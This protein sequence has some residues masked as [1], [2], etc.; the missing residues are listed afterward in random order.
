MGMSMLREK[1]LAKCE[2]CGTL[3]T[4]N[5]STGVCQDCWDKDEE[6]FQKV[7]SAIK[8]GQRVLPDE[9]AT[10]TGVELKHINRWIQQG[11][12]G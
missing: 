4:G 12:F 6:M 9:L 8:F 11:R 2:M 7:K 5:V 10:K 3:M 1:R